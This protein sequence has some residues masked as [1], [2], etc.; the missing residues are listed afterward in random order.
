MTNAYTAMDNRPH[1]SSTSWIATVLRKR[2]TWHFDAWLVETPDGT[3]W[4]NIEISEGG[5]RGVQQIWFAVAPEIGPN[6]YALRREKDHTRWPPAELCTARTL[7]NA[8]L[9]AWRGYDVRVL[10]IT[11]WASIVPMIKRPT[12][13]KWTSVALHYITAASLEPLDDADNWH[14]YSPQA[15]REKI[16]PAT[17]RHKKGAR[18]TAPQFKQPNPDDELREALHRISLDTGL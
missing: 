8:R 16:A 14:R 13:Y 2:S 6:G 12:E 11:H 7:D 3:L 17:V 9:L 4:F 18:V 10:N 15:K 5:I 1:V